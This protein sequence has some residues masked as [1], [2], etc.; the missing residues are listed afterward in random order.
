MN[1]IVDYFVPQQDPIL[2][3]RSSNVVERLN[4]DNWHS[5]AITQKTAGSV[6]YIYLSYAKKISGRKRYYCV[7][8]YDVDKCKALS[9]T[10]FQ[11]VAQAL[12]FVNDETKDH[13]TMQRVL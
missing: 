7:H 1:N 9:K 13:S 4:M 5:K 10:L 3:I 8:T 12:A 6:H 11:S 2:G